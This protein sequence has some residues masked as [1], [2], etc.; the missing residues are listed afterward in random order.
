MMPIGK[1]IHVIDNEE[2]IDVV[3]EGLM[4]VKTKEK[5][6]VVPATVRYDDEKIGVVLE[7][8]MYF[9]VEEKISVLKKDILEE[10]KIKILD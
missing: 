1:T 6:G 4:R 3:W 10:R 2:K 7:V 9:M 5:I 8:L